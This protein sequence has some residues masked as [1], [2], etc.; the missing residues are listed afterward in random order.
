M[1]FIFGR[2]FSDV[3]EVLFQSEATS[4]LASTSDSM[5]TKEYV[6]IG[7]CSLLLGLIYVASVFLY[8]HMKKRK[9]RQQSPH[10]RNSLDDITN[11]INYPKNDQV[12]FG[13]PFNRSGSIYSATS[14]GTSNE[15][16]SRT[17]IGSFKEEMGIIKS[18]PLLQHFP[19]L[20]EHN[21]GFASDISNSNSECEMDGTLQEKLKQVFC[22]LCAFFHLILYA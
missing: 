13:A 18:N 11:E 5:S 22:M 14:M 20:S 1:F 3:S 17:S 9:G 21:S 6:V 12:T 2:P 19:Q 7:V 10:T 4:T 16:R 15:P 8:L